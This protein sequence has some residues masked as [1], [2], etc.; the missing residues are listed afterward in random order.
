MSWGRFPLVLWRLVTAYQRAAEVHAVRQLS[1][2]TRDLKAQWADLT[3]TRTGNKPSNRGP[4]KRYERL[5]DFRA[6]LVLDLRNLPVT[7]L[8][9][10]STL[11]SLT[12]SLVITAETP[13]CRALSA[14]SSSLKNLKLSLFGVCDP[15][16]FRHFRNLPQL[17][18]LTWLCLKCFK[19]LSVWKVARSLLLSA[20]RLQEFEFVDSSAEEVIPLLAAHPSLSVVTLTATSRV[21]RML[22][23]DRALL[24]ISRLEVNHRL[25]DRQQL[26]DMAGIVGD[27]AKVVTDCH[28]LVVDFRSC[29][30]GKG[31]IARVVQ[32]DHVAPSMS[33]LEASL[34]Q[35]SL[36]DVTFALQELDLFEHIV[37]IPCQRLHLLGRLCAD[38]LWATRLCGAVSLDT[39]VLLDTGRLRTDCLILEDF[40]LSCT[41]RPNCRA[42]LELRQCTLKFEVQDM[43]GLRDMK[44]V[45]CTLP[46]GDTINRAC[47]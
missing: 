36:Q 34:V 11:V 42:S 10:T 9:A 29:H 16:P 47:I 6:V 21:L 14:C 7:L 25:E 15:G 32:L 5:V 38:R 45:A 12:L 41:F 27:T 40:V 33:L 46:N 23:S 2:H 13:F 30:M 3:V 28:S 20:T 26:L 18:S 24:A 37:A 31:D 39:G 17:Q 1:S 8:T 4:E 19:V 22:R 44:L 35:T 43:R